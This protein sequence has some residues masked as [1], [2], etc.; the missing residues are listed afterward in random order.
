[1]R[2]PLLTL[3]ALCIALESLG[4]P[5]PAHAGTASGI[6]SYKDRISRTLVLVEQ[7]QQTQGPQRRQ[8]IARALLLLPVTMTTTLGGTAVKADLSAVRADLDASPPRLAYAATAL[9]VLR[10]ALD[11]PA[12]QIES[13]RAAQAVQTQSGLLD[14]ILHHPPFHHDA[15]LWDNIVQ[16][17]VQGPLGAL[18]RSVTSALRQLFAPLGGDTSGLGSFLPW[19]AGLI[20]AIAIVVAVLLLRRPFAPDIEDETGEAALMDLGAVNVDAEGARARAAA[21]ASAG[22]YRDAGRYLFL[23][24]LLT[25]DEAGRLRVDRATGNRDILRQARATPRLAEALTPVVRLFDRFWFGR[26][27]F[28]HDDYELYRGLNDKVIE[29]VR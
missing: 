18:W 19:I 11:A 25:L 2:L 22:R 9:S 8:D 24:T 6:G 27:T 16:W 26:T 4:G 7:A 13:A 15:S 17:V 5:S 14:D 1:V 3:V 23:S 28:T 21:F 20:V 10:A 12:A 29:V